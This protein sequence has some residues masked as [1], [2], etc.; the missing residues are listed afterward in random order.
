MGK[1]EFRDLKRQYN[2]I[3]PE[4][5]QAIKDVIESTSFIM[6]QPI[7]DLE[8]I[9]ATY[10]GRKHCITVASGT[11]ALQLALMSMDIGPG[12]AV[13][14]SDYTYFASASCASVIGATPVF[15]DIEPDTF[16]I[17]SVDLETQIQRIL[18]E[19]KLTPKAIIPV[20][21]FGLPAD[22]T[23]IGEI[24]KKYELKIVEDAAQGFGGEYNGKRT[25]SF[26]DVSTTSFFPSKP[27][28]CYGDGGAIFTDEDYIDIR[29]RSLR[30]SGRSAT[31]KYDNIE[32]G[33]NSRL[34]TIQAAILIRKF[35][36]FKDYE[37]NAINEVANWYSERLNQSC[38]IPHV[39][40]G[41][42]SSWAQYTILLENEKERDEAQKKL[43]ANNIPSMIYYP[44]GLHQQRAYRWMELDDADYPN[45]IRAT[46]R[47]LSLPIHP[48]LTKEEVDE[49]IRAILQP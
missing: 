14:T 24:A 49:V 35:R 4:I 26:G 5:D 21:L 28:G 15:V 6:G 37:L 25:C 30:A 45:T 34:D 38:I 11:E 18:Q 1:I 3:K 29:L 12:D 42:L 40:D 43:E 27:L 41:Y 48:Y 9:L 47:C 10:V 36:V 22:Y 7:M 33:I 32:I 44:R 13:F 8:R 39:S 16:N 20:D 31:D 19:G 17:S 23:A 46:K 2:A